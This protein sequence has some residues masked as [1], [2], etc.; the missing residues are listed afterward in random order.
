M[1]NL[2]AIILGLII[3][4]GINY[5]FAGSYTSP[6]CAPT[7]CN[8]DIPINITNIAQS[9]TGSLSIGT[10]NPIAPGYKFSAVGGLSYLQGLVT[11]GITITGNE[12]EGKVLKYSASTGLASW[13]YLNT[14][15]PSDSTMTVKDFSIS[16]PREGEAS[17]IIP[18]TYQYCAIS[19]L[20]PD[21]ANS[22]KSASVCSVNRNT[23][24]T[25]SLYGKRLNDPGFLCNARCF[26][27]ST[28]EAQYGNKTYYIP[29]PGTYNE[30]EAKALGLVESSLVGNKV[31]YGN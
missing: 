31:Y 18:N 21:F 11:T 14:G 4:L 13:Q 3:T 9:K 15:I 29:S 25:W 1:K 28:K 27:L 22:D 17:T 26:S 16:I 30:T 7:G 8:T 6:K 12:G 24:A 2:K 20:G 23:D 5:T 10:N 19:Q